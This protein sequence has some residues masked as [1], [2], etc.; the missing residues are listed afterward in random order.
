[1]IRTTIVLATLVT[2]GFSAT[3]TLAQ[4]LNCARV[5]DPDGWVNVRDLS[6][7]QVVGRLNNNT[8]FAYRSVT[9]DGY[10]I[11]VSALNR[12]V[13]QSRLERVSNQFC[14]VFWTVQD[15]EGWSNL[16]ASPGGDIIGR[17]RSGGRVLKIG[18]EEDWA[19]V[20]TSEGTFGYIHSSRL[21]GMS[22]W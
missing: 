18:G 11:L 5:Q 12:G 17:V 22:T 14:T 16:R 9:S 8:H 1:M 6:S 13:H 20:I 19:E 3:P 4:S 7:G 21:R 10:A 2:L 15:E